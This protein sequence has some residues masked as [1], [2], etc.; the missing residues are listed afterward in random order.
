MDERTFNDAIAWLNGRR[1][2]DAGLELLRRA[3]FKPAVVA[4][5]AR[6]GKDGP[7]CMERLTFQV[8]ELLKAIGRPVAVEDTDAELHVFDGAEAPADHNEHQQ[9]GIIKTA[10]LME[11]GKVE[12]TPNA[13]K[14]V[15]LY[16]QV[17]KGREQAM[18][19]LA[20]AGESND[21]ETMELRKRLSDQIDALTSLM[22]RLYPLFERSQSGADI[23]PE[24]V[25]TAIGNKPAKQSDPADVESAAQDS[26]AGH[27]LEGKTREE[28]VQ[29]RKNA[30][31][32][33]LR[34]QNKLQYQSEKKA[35]TDNPM[36]EGPKRTQLEARARQLEAEIKDYDLAIAHFG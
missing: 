1:D 28:L 33:L 35:D 26:G 3:G 2:F 27:T 22:E 19:A 13:A 17:Y 24:E 18:R 30:Q 16:S 14:V 31:V 8:R 29:L 10:Q 20:D 12:L 5:L 25:S 7:A 32:R 9:I 15:H 34:T 21:A 36:P 11:Q 4:K 6:D 23:T